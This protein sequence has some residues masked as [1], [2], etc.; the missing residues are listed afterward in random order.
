MP[1]S[2]SIISLR[3]LCA[4]CFRATNQIN[5]FT[6]LAHLVITRR[7]WNDM[8]NYMRVQIGHFCRRTC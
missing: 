3:E 6:F 8:Y 7:Q 2:F 5:N 4:M 1:F